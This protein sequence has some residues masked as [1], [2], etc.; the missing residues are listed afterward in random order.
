M[1]RIE[2][3]IRKACDM[4]NMIEDGDRIAIG[5]SGG[6]DS[7]ALVA[8]LAG[9]A[10]YYDRHFDIVAISLDPCFGGAETDFAPVT[11]MC[12]SFGIEHHIKRTNLG[13][14]IFDIRKESN[15][16]SLCARMR[17]G[18]LHDMCNALGCGKIAL[19]HHMDDAVETFFLNLFHEGRMAAFYPKTWLSRKEIT[20]IRPLILCT[21]AEVQSAANRQALPVVKSRCPVDGVSERQNIKNFIVQK[22]REYP[23]FLQRTFTAMQ[24]GN[25]SGLGV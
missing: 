7:V 10:K 6:K 17:R 2:G 16:C 1:K 14:I 19:G 12:K 21:E 4:Y 18:A 3:K 23:G 8:G 22:E 24:N 25:I 13:E 15:P 11:E 5:V 9:L 20:A